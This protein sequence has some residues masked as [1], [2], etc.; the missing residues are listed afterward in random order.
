M[1]DEELDEA[2]LDDT[3][4][5]SPAPPRPFKHAAPTAAPAAPAVAPAAAPPFPEAPAAAAPAAAAATAVATA[6]AVAKPK[7][8]LK[9][10]MKV[11]PVGLVAPVANK[12]APKAAKALPAASGAAK[13]PRIGGKVSKKV[14]K[15]D[16]DTESYGDESEVS[17]GD[18]DSGE[19]A[20]PVQHPYPLLSLVL[21]LVFHNA[22]VLSLLAVGVFSTFSCCHRGGCCYIQGDGAGSE[23]SEKWSWWCCCWHLPLC[24]R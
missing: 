3:P 18:A 8:K 12:P 10:V 24:S 11:K 15:D 17:A 20:G 1:E 2:L 6:A 21:L 23:K 5:A 4:P 7:L 13:R 19:E 22:V 14:R 9:K 16:S